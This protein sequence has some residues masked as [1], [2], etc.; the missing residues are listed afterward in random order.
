[1]CCFPAGPGVWV[2]C[3]AFTQLPVAAALPF[4]FRGQLCDGFLIRNPLSPAWTTHASFLLFVS[5][6]CADRPPPASV[7]CACLHTPSGRSSRRTVSNFL[8][9]LFHSV[10]RSCLYGPALLARLNDAVHC[11]LSCYLRQFLL[12]WALSLL[13]S[14][15]CNSVAGTQG[16]P[17]YIARLPLPVVSRTL[18]FVYVACVFLVSTVF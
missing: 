5:T 7:G 9:V 1:M 18:H 15:V 11:L 3:F 16:E 13:L 8:L 14:S 17:F 10:R 4:F 6:H 12:A 2:V